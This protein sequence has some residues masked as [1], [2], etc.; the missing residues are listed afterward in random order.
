MS[1]PRPYLPRRD[2][3]PIVASDWRRVAA[4]HQA[5]IA[6]HDHVDGRGA[7]LTGESFDPNT[8]LRVSSITT[9][10]LVVNDL[11]V[12]TRLDATLPRS[13]GTIT[14]GLAVGGT[15]RVGGDVVVSAGP[16]VTAL[17]VLPD[18]VA[19]PDVELQ[20]IAA[21]RDA[22]GNHGQRAVATFRPIEGA[23]LSL[24]IED[25]S[26]LL[27]SALVGFVATAIYR[28]GDTEYYVDPV[29]DGMIAL[30]AERGGRRGLVAGAMQTGGTL[31]LDALLDAAPSPE[32]IRAGGLVSYEKTAYSRPIAQTW[33]IQVKPGPLRLGLSGCGLG[34]FQ[35]ASLH[36]TTLPELA[37]V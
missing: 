22:N 28:T 9:G 7:P 37:H 23:E 4:A 31:A 19:S 15:L 8:D 16:P 29:R 21:L 1:A 17:G 14:G 26:L 11:D 3:D 2:G 10:A 13:G 34:T 12:A 20:D 24:E 6:A 5:A 35:S 33:L 18:P 32:I 27:I 25:E 36:V 30:W